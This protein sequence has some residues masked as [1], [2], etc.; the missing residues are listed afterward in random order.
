MAERLPEAHR[1]AP[2][3]RWKLV[4]GS[5]WTTLA[6]RESLPGSWGGVIVAL[7]LAFFAFSTILGW[8][9][10]GE[11]SLQ[12]LLGPWVIVPYRIL[13]SVMVVVGPMAFGR[14]IWLFSDVMN[15]LMAIP[16]LVGV[17]LLSGLVARETR[18]Y[19]RRTRG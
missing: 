2:L 17:L 10:Y 3:I 5:E 13:F 12:Y 15:G 19:F 4:S 7:S 9:Y 11:R 1:L 18:S 14:A 8:S 16:N 6:F